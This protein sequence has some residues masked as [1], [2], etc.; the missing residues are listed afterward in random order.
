MQLLS[1]DPKPIPD[2]PT[3]CRG[4]GDELPPLRRWGG[5]CRDCVHRV[6]AANGRG[7]HVFRWK[8]IEFFTRTRSNGERQSSVRVR[9]EC[10][11]SVRTMSIT[12]Y[13]QHK[14]LACRRCLLKDIRAR[15]VESDYAK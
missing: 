8:A 7:P 12:E 3:H 9:C 15:G 11:L 6:P 10:G 13:E 4:C 2:T 5:L 1:T 14:S